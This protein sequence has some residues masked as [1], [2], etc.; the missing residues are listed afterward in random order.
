MVEPFRNIEREILEYCYSTIICLE[1]YYHEFTIDELKKDKRFKGI[2]EN[3]IFY[4]IDQLNKAY[5][6]ESPTLPRKSYFNISLDG[7]LFLERFYLKEQQI[8][9]PLTVNTLDFLKNIEDGIIT[10]NPGEGYQIG[11]FLI[12]KF[13]KNLE[14]TDRAEEIKLNFVIDE[15][16][17]FRKE[18]NYT[19]SN[20]FGSAGNKLVFFST[21]LL[22]PKGRKFLSYHQKLKKLFSTLHDKFAK[23]IILEEYN[24]IEHL[25][26]RE[27]WKD[28]FIKMESILEFLITNYIEENNLDKKV[29]IVIRGQR[30]SINPLKTSFR[31]QITFIIQHEIFDK[32]Y[33]NDWKIV[34]GLMIKLRNYIHLYQ[35]IKDRARVSKDL[36]DKFYNVFER[37]I[38]L[39]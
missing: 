12:S 6:I 9:I 10:L 1:D 39:F 36:F 15:I 34:E 21:L 22:T 13:L 16:S 5:Y 26:K 38:L 17:K 20:S 19:Y 4:C 14:I 23:E 35:Y 2:N 31:K 33:I 25:R 3:K 32:S 30:R 27:K 18:E 24:E 28:A 7:I 8:F 37:L 11:S 29:E